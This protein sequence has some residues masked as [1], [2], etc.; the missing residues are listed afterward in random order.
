MT[1]V[2]EITHVFSHLKWFVQIIE[3]IPEENFIV[4]E[5]KLDE[6]QLWV[7]LTDLSKVAL[8]TP[9]VKMFKFFKD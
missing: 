5:E 3:C 7:K 4:Q 2:G 1:K 9:Q 8:P 6:N